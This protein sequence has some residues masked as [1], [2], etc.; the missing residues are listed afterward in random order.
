MLSSFITEESKDITTEAG[1][2]RVTRKTNRL[3]DEV[4]YVA[5]EPLTSLSTH[6]SFTQNEGGW[7]GNVSERVLSPELDKK[8]EGRRERW[9]AVQAY[10]KANRELA[11]SLIVQAY[12]EAA[13]GQ[14]I[15]GSIILTLDALPERADSD[16]HYAL[17]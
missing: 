6:N 4:S 9:G 10:Y 17:R 16:G 8:Y 11:H 3:T 13:H 14:S 1:S 15:M 7:W 5:Y 2:F 12:P